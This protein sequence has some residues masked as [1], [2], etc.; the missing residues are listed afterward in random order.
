MA[1]YEYRCEECGKVYTLLTNQEK[2]YREVA[3]S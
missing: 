2:I 1:Q 3:N